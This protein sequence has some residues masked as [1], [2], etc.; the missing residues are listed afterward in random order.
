[1]LTVEYAKD[2]V[3]NSDD[4]QQIFLIVKFEQIEEELPFN[5]TSFDIM[6][7]GVDLF[8][9]AVLGEFGEIAPY[10]PPPENTQPISQGAQTL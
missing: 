9:R 2:P 10:V 6:P 4:G 1:M 3:W 7:Y 5:A 8:N